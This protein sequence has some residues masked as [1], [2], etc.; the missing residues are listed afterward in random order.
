MAELDDQTE[1]LVQQLYDAWSTNADPTSYLNLRDQLLSRRER[2]DTCIATLKTVITV[3]CPQ[4][5]ETER[6]FDP[7]WE[8][9]FALAETIE[10]S[11]EEDNGTLG[12]RKRT[13]NEVHRLRNLAVVSALWSPGVVRHYGWNSAAQGCLRLLKTCALRFPNFGKQFCP[14]LNRVLLDRHCEAIV[15]GHLKTLNEAPLQCY[16]DLNIV[17]GG[18]VVPNLETEELWV[19]SSDGAVPVDSNGRL[20]KDVRPYHFQQHL[21]RRDRYSMLVARGE[22]RDLP[23]ITHQQSN[24]S[25]APSVYEE[26]LANDDGLL[27]NIPG[28]TFSPT[29]MFTPSAVDSLDS[30]AFSYQTE[31]LPYNPNDTSTITLPSD[32]AA[33]LA[34]NLDEVPVSDNIFSSDVPEQCPGESNNTY[35]MSPGTRNNSRRRSQEESVA[36]LSKTTRAARLPTSPANSHARTGAPASRPKGKPTMEDELRKKH[37]QMLSKYIQRLNEETVP[38]YDQRRVRSQWLTSDT[39]WARIWSIS[40]SKSLPPGT[41]TSKANCDV[42]YCSA[43]DMLEA[44]RSGEV[45][46]KPVIIKES[47]SDTGMHNYERF[48]SLLEDAS[49]SDEQVEVRCIDIK[50]PMHEGLGK[51]TAYLRSHPVLTDGVWMSTTRSVAK[52]HRPLFTML[53]RF[54][55]LESLSEG[56]HGQSSNSAPSSLIKAMSVS[57]NTISF[58]G[59]FSG[60][61]LNSP[62]GSWQRNL[63]GVKFWVFVPD[64]GVSLDELASLANEGDGWLP[65]GKQRLVILEENDVLFVPPGLRLVQAWHAPTTC[66]TEQGMLWDDLSILSIV[67]SLPW[68]RENQAVQDDRATQQLFRMI[69]NL[70]C[71]I[72]EQPDR[73]RRRMAQDEFISRFREASQSW[74]VSCS[75]GG[76]KQ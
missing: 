67:E 75:N 62:A 32:D 76:R 20:L 48:L 33:G 61:H 59:A 65:R 7:K 35:N 43:D 17:V 24:F 38:G 60:V 19:T 41:A 71:L 51:F 69:N 68:G 6:Y 57:F 16:R 45:F 56:L 66:L 74:L 58:P 11:A 29:D 39:K 5:T 26:F 72:R 22:C 63:S 2:V 54:R 44:A 31:T 42:L 4:I 8:E 50:Q 46:Q 25:L 1:S 40:G 52:C 49:S 9:L 23:V 64:T 14:Y 15:S 36:S 10:S 13:Y 30:L 21:L 70:D 18:A 73:F 28:L 3:T 27:A 55:L 37:N 34:L 53:N 47:F 12:K